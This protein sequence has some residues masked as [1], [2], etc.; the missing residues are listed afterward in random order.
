MSA[1]KTDSPALHVRTNPPRSRRIGLYRAAIYSMAVI[2]CA[3]CWAS[4]RGYKTWVFRQFNPDYGVHHYALQPEI[5]RTRPADREGNVSPGSAFVAADVELPYSG[6]VVDGRSLNGDSVRLYR[7]YDGRAVPAVVNTSGAGDAIVLR[8]KQSLDASTQY[9]F[10]V[11]PA[12]TDTAG[13]RFKP[14]TTT[15]WTMAGER[16]AEFPVAFEKVPLPDA[17]GHMFTCV[18]IGPDRKLYA[19][20]LSGK[21]FR[22]AIHPDGAIEA[23]L[24]INTVNESNGL[25]RLI[26]GIA[27]DPHATADHL[28]LWVSHGQLTSQGAR[29]RV[30]SRAP[31]I[32]PAKSAG[33][34][35]PILKNIRTW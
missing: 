26:T 25:S 23:P 24:E 29:G 13:H 32:G 5:I 1:V 18:T 6:K 31:P 8:P 35:D 16:L 15:F 33:S 9:T 27:F 4:G 11:T 22:Y 17:I 3:C 2:L 10:E 7:T 14:F 19:S 20:T 34:K 12:V 28:L 21:I 30:T